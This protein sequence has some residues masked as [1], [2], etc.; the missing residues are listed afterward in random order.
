MGSNESLRLPYRLEP[1]ECRI[2]HPSLTNPGRFMGLLCSIVRIPVIY[3]DR[4][5]NQF[6]V[7][8]AITAQLIRHDLPGLP[9]M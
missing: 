6:P 8:N 4:I 3:I 7:S 9:A 2:T 1:S 5:R